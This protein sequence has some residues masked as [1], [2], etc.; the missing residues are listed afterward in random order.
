M[1]RRNDV[2]GVLLVL[3]SGVLWGTVGPARELMASGAGAAAIGGARIFSGGLVL[4]LA[5]LVIRPRAFRALG[6]PARGPLLAAATATGIFQPAFLGAVGRTGAALA[7]AVA[8]GLV[9][10]ATGLCESAVLGTRPSRRWWAATACAVA[11]CVLLVLPGGHTRPDPLGV[12]LGAVAALCFG[13]Y[14]VSAKALAGRLGAGADGM[15]ATLAAVAVTLLLGGAVLLPWTAAAA[16]ALAAPRS[17]A[18]IA[19]LGLATTALGYTC[20][21]AGLHR[22]SAATAGTLSLAEPLV[23]AA[24][25]LAVLHERPSPAA[26]AGAVLLL[27]GLAAVSVPA[28][29]AMLGRTRLAQSRWTRPPGSDPRPDTARLGERHPLPGVPAGEP[30]A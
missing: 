5:V 21:I 27:A 7:T 30:P 2:P 22:V 3:A 14:T 6:R 25:A 19:W 29:A 11:G 17:A 20:F 13:V 9:P 1:E 16:P 18:L 4:A 26:A 10:V 12:A 23:S 8:F 24:L 15:A 28:P